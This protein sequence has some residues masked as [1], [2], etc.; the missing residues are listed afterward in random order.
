MVRRAV[1][2]FHQIVYEESDYYTSE[3]TAAAD[4]GETF[5][6]CPMQN[7]SCLLKCFLNVL[8]RL[9][10]GYIRPRLF[11]LWWHVMMAVFYVLRLIM[12]NLLNT[13]RE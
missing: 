13:M 12:Y 8:A 1:H 3:T 7:V 11:L 6:T 10:E 4:D 9:H 5:G 2:E